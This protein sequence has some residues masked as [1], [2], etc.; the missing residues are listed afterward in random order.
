M[1]LCTT[2]HPHVTFPT[3]SDQV[4]LNHGDIPNL[5][6]VMS[7]IHLVILTR[8]HSFLQLAQEAWTQ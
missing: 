6:V 5:S 1:H 3:I 2:L 7:Q 4:S 8:L